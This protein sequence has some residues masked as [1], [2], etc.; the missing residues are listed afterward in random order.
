MENIVK[1]IFVV[2]YKPLTD[3]KEYIDEFFKENNITNYEFRDHYQRED[4]TKELE[5]TY[6]RLS[7]SYYKL[8]ASQIC[9]TIEHIE[10][11][12]EIVK[13]GNNDV[14]YL[15][16]EDDAIFCNGFIDLLGEYMKNVPK[17]AE[18]LDICDYS[19]VYTNEY[20][21]RE[22]RTRTACAYLIKKS[23]CEKMLTTIVPFSMEIDWALMTEFKIHN[24][25]V[26]W[27]GKP[28]I[29]HGS[30]EDF[31]GNYIKSYVR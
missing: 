14:W 23:T 11:Y 5:D 20:W 18:Y 22:N 3:R 30:S 16:I 27:S 25:N 13:E 4:F 24:I 28:L 7:P 10:I 31:N 9:I 15:I 29:H 6:Y 21:V 1:K 17:N 12:R 26:Y 19:Q 2:H 8:N